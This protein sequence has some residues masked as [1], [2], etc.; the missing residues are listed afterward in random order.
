MG[1]YIYTMRKRKQTFLLP[2]GER[3]E[4][5]LYSYAYKPFR[6]FFGDNRHARR[7]ASLEAA[8]ERAFGTYEGG[9]VIV[10]DLEKGVDRLDGTTVY[11]QV[12]RA[13][14]ADCNEFPGRALGF[15]EVRNK[16]CYL[17]TERPWYRF[18]NQP[19]RE[20][21]E[22]IKDGKVITEGR[23]TDNHTPIIRGETVND[24]GERI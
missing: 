14:H 10:G 16:R 15:I 11:D 24:K 23:F 1:T 12:K 20:Y 2:S 6:G 17:V 4:A 13:T 9:Y 3:A 21:R 8:G 22:V 18:D 19:Y 7:E 5:N